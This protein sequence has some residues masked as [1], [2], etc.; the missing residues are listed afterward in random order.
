MENYLFMKNLV[1]C[2]WRWVGDILSFRVT[3]EDADYRHYKAIV[4]GKKWMVSYCIS[5]GE[6][7]FVGV[8]DDTYDYINDPDGWDMI[9]DDDPDKTVYTRSEIIPDILK[10]AIEDDFRKRGELYDVA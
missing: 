4:Y 5:E 6:V 10:K 9:E 8:Q 1:E 3:Y 2:V 7:A